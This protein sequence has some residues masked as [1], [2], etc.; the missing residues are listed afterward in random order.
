V[1]SACV[2][3]VQVECFIVSFKMRTTSVQFDYFVMTT[4]AHKWGLLWL[5]SLGCW[6]GH[7]GKSGRTR[8]SCILCLIVV[9]FNDVISNWDCIASNGRL[10]N[11]HRIG[12][13][14]E[15]SVSGL[16]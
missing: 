7:E 5:F 14:V 8:G 10:S 16:I 3:K 2:T 15:G 12:K 1:A 13:Y 6:M 4:Y 11:E 9:Y